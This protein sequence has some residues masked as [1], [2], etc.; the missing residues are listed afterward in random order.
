MLQAPPTDQLGH[1]KPGLEET[2]TQ[3][4]AVMLQCPYADAT[5]VSS[6]C[7]VITAVLFLGQTPDDSHQLWR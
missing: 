6:R 3:T 5:C 7:L 4:V 2:A 1:W